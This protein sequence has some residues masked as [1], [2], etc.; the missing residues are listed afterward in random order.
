MR[1]HGWQTP[2]LPSTQAPE[3][4]INIKANVTEMTHSLAGFYFHWNKFSWICFSEGEWRVGLSPVVW[5][6][7]I[8]ERLACWSPLGCSLGEREGRKCCHSLTVETLTAEEL[9][10]GSLLKLQLCTLGFTLWAMSSKQR[11][12]LSRNLSWRGSKTGI[13]K[14]INAA[15]AIEKWKRSEK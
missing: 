2:N 6:K 15:N 7:S 1:S 12:H 3:N 8:A 11:T 5:Q 14:V 4:E 9:A 13:F 10:A